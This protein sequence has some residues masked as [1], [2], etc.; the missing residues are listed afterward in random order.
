[1]TLLHY[2]LITSFIVDAFEP[3]TTTAVFG[4]G[5]CYLGNKLYK[6]LYETCDDTWIHFNSS[7]KFKRVVLTIVYCHDVLQDSKGKLVSVSSH[8]SQYDWLKLWLFLVGS[9]CVSHKL[10]LSLYRKQ[11]N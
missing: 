2:I 11:K 9:C 1:M 4:A 6:F 10:V 5:A 8:C 7:S 3:I